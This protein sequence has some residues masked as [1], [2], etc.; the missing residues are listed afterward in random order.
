MLYF[1]RTPTLPSAVAI[2]LYSQFYYSFTANCNRNLSDFE[3]ITSRWL[4]LQISGRLLSIS[5]K[6]L[7]VWNWFIFN[8]SETFKSEPYKVVWYQIIKSYSFTSTWYIDGPWFLCTV[9]FSSSKRL[10]NKI[11]NEFA[12]KWSAACTIA[13]LLS[14]SALFYWISYEYRWPHFN[15]SG[16]FFCNTSTFKSLENKFSKKNLST[17]FL[18][19]T[20]DDIKFKLKI[21]FRTQYKSLLL[22]SWY[23]GTLSFNFLSF[24]KNELIFS[25]FAKGCWNRLKNNYIF[26]KNFT[27]NLISYFTNNSNKI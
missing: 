23:R 17:A 20:D 1:I 14:R 27:K 3:K 13:K 25:M 15:D 11:L 7:K 19:V 2:G 22:I 26:K 18:H 10:W 24:N 9:F 16:I 4:L 12:Q 6:P 21:C 5:S 8:S